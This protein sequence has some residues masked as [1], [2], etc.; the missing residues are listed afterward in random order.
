MKLLRIKKDAAGNLDDV[1]VQQA[2]LAGRAAAADN[3]VNVSD[4]INGKTITSIFEADGIT[5]RKATSAG[6]AGN[7]ASTINLKR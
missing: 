2:D 4:T 5:A 6:S 1:K 7:V 3:A